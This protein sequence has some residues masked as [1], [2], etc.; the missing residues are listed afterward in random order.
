MILLFFLIFYF[1]SLS[2]SLSSHMHTDTNNV[3]P[4]LFIS[5][6]FLSLFPRSNFQG[7]FVHLSTMVG[8]YLNQLCTVLRGEKEVILCYRRKKSTNGQYVVYSCPLLHV[9]SIGEN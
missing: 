6:V 8:A 7:P 1:L 9:F 5:W 2:L 4:A 3:F